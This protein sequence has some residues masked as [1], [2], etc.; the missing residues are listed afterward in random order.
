MNK[1]IHTDTA[2][3]FSVYDIEDAKNDKWSV[4]MDYESRLA[5]LDIDREAGVA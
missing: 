5:K 2:P 1:T 3:Y 4:P